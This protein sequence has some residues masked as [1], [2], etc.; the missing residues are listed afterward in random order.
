MSSDFAVT[1]EKRPVKNFW[2]GRG[3]FLPIAIVE[4]M[5]QGSIEDAEQYFNGR[6]PEGVF[7]VSA[8][9]GVA[10]D[11]R[12]WQFVEDDD[13]AW[14]NGVL[15]NP[16][17][18]VD[19]LK[20]VYQEKVNCNLVTLSIDYEGYSGEPLT[21]RQYDAALSLHRQ[22]VQRWDIEPDNQHIIGHNW[23]DS[24]ERSHNPGPLFPFRQ[25]LKDL[26][27]PATTQ[28]A[29]PNPLAFLETPLP[30]AETE[31]ETAAPP[32]STAETAT[33]GGAAYQ[34]ET[35]EEPAYR[36]QVE[37]FTTPPDLNE[38]IDPVTAAPTEVDPTTAEPEPVQAETFQ[39]TADYQPEI[40]GEEAVYQPEE[41][42][43]AAPVE[44]FQTVAQAET[45]DYLPPETATQDQPADA[46]GAVS[47]PEE[48]E[49]TET[50]TTHAAYQPQESQPAEETEAEAASEAESVQAPEESVEAPAQ[51]DVIDQAE[52]APQ[53]EET[54]VETG[55]EEIS[56]EAPSQPEEASPE[57]QAEAATRAEPLQPEAVAS[58][59]TSEVDD[60]LADLAYIP[61]GVITAPLRRPAS[62]AQPEASAAPETQTLPAQSE[63]A[64]AAPPETGE[65]QAEAVEPQAEQAAPALHSGVQPGSQ[66][67]VFD[68]PGQ[69]A[70]L[71]EV[72]SAIFEQAEL[73]QVAP[74]QT[75]PGAAPEQAMPLTVEGQE[76]APEQ[77]AFETAEPISEE[78]SAGQIAQ[79]TEPTEGSVTPEQAGHV[80][81]DW[82]AD[83]L[84][85][86]PFPMVENDAATAV[87]ETAVPSDTATGTSEVSS[88]VG[89][90]ITPKY[91]RPEFF[92]PTHTSEPTPAEP[93]SMAEVFDAPVA[94]T[95]P[96]TQ[97]E[98]ATQQPIA[99]TTT[100][101]VSVP[102]AETTVQAAQALE[103]PT[104]VTA[105][106][107]LQETSSPAPAQQTPTPEAAEPD[108]AESEK[109]EEKHHWYDRIKNFFG[110]EKVPS[111]ETAPIP[112]PSQP[113]EIVQGTPFNQV[114]AAAPETVEGTL[115]VETGPV[116]AT[117]AAEE[118]YTTAPEPYQ[119]NYAAEQALFQ[120]AE[121]GSI[122]AATEPN[123]FETPTAA[124]PEPETAATVSTEAV[125]T[126]PEAA[127]EAAPVVPEPQVPAES[128][129]EQVSSQAE[130]EVTATPSA[131]AAP[132][133]LQ[134]ETT[135][136]Q[137]APANPPV[138]TAQVEESSYPFELDTPGPANYSTYYRSGETEDLTGQSNDYDFN[139]TNPASSYSQDYNSSGPSEYPFELP[140][141]QAQPNYRQ[142]FAPP[143][144][145]S[146]QPV[147]PVVEQPASPIETVAPEAVEA[148]QP[149]VPS[150]AAEAIQP[151]TRSEAAETV[152]M[153]Q[154]VEPEQT[155]APEP[156]PPGE[157]T[158]PGEAAQPVMPPFSFEPEKPGDVLFDTNAAAPGQPKFGYDDLQ[159]PDW[160][161]E[162]DANAG[163]AGP[164]A[165]L[166]T[167]SAAQETPAPPA[168]DFAW[169]NETARPESAVPGWL[170]DSN[171]AVGVPE[172]LQDNNEPANPSAETVQAIPTVPANARKEAPAVEI[173]NK[174]WQDNENLFE[175]DDFFSQLNQSGVDLSL[176][177]G[178]TGA[179][180]TTAPLTEA[181]AAPTEPEFDN[182]FEEVPETPPPAKMT[183]QQLIDRNEG[184]TAPL[185]YDD[186]DMSVPFGLEEDTSGTEPIQLAAPEPVAPPPAPVRNDPPGFHRVDLGEGHTSVELAN[187]RTV[188]SYDKNT[189]LRVSEQGERFVFDG[190]MEGPELRGSTRWYHIAASGG[191]QWIHSTLVQLDRPFRG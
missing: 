33:E 52:A 114:E 38:E 131:E 115:P 27:S 83:I 91:S 64:S 128:A 150:E 120:S 97:P 12:V 30:G 141:Q 50:E 54:A 122:E 161:N 108:E 62:T 156:A 149:S 80:Q 174:D 66:P 82:A 159:L 58:P 60:I 181:Q 118:V 71:A 93:T 104:E 79:Q 177:R 15:Q 9:Y 1:I 188:P 77:V 41:I 160:L 111:V 133:A 187:V 46:A 102:S 51:S 155:S 167:A 189:V 166:P 147:A 105:P 142:S 135:H 6:S 176:E 84:A 81:D 35:A 18:S 11:G 45:A 57:E 8:H 173:P 138:E 106:E 55:P 190:W 53:P 74:E 90:D 34:P 112:A 85:E 100:P 117:E 10:R 125:P 28:P 103:F 40:V 21:P 165:T 95:A 163:S 182:Y 36:P 20:E 5:I 96:D 75:A 146:E 175:D 148:T 76:A 61:K 23:I 164:T 49:P 92:D 171:E 134:P 39:D 121:P 25:L 22:L 145:S 87:Q 26:Q 123:Q 65:A 158:Q 2:K 73:E 124:T 86:A 69:P 178:G 137:A 109:T 89:N 184:Y 110:G 44:T 153:A 140:T 99:A 152:Q 63:A 169:S 13:T 143:V 78:T 129:T 119:P 154:S 29:Q 162:P 31:T 19:W 16:D 183:V 139:S 67:E 42:E 113:P 116:P 144:P 107:A 72:E 3:G 48:T 32:L 168:P 88:P 94:E 68:A 130:P 43:T 151:P 180:P 98:A 179:L 24:L 157:P 70:H 4:R 186:L 7:A 17:L 185:S 132:A 170:Q 37:N 127:T 47:Q 136:Q 126:E 14:S 191:E 56:A 101:G 59:E 172:W